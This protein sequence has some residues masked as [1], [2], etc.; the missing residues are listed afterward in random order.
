MSAIAKRGFLAVV[1]SALMCMGG[2]LLAGCQQ[3]AE[4]P[5]KDEQ[6]VEEVSEPTFEQP[7]YVLLVGNDSRTGTVGISE[8]QYADGSGRSDVMMLMRVDPVTYKIT[9]LT[10]PRD[11][12]A[13]VNGATAKINTA[14]QQGGIQAT[15]DQVKQLTGVDA[16]YYFDLGF[17]SFE[18]FVN[19][20]GGI[21]VNVP[22]NMSL[23]D[24]VS[25]NDVSL[26][27]GEQTLDGAEALVLART[28]K[29]YTQDQDAIRQMQDRAIVTA[30]ITQVVQNPD[31]VD[32]AVSALMNNAD[33]N[34]SS[35]ELT[36]LVRSF[37]EHADQL[38][39]YQATGPYAGGIDPADNMWY[40][41]RDEVT[42]AQII[43]T[44][45]AGEDPSGIVS[46]PA[47][48]L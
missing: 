26:A 15:L 41:T 38:T 22:A 5:V 16:S 9:L 14:Y 7:F 42:W 31:M 37:A 6:I 10:V 19:D 12:Q 25:G 47:I 48:S 34:M 29:I 28:R 13:T 4:E 43:A 32:V 21:T 17:V 40:T 20:L 2:C 11:T 46:E 36:T 3:Q 23:Q 24:I 33:T 30:G 44:A 8:A 39:I 27:A 1:L 18:Q 35:D 45:D